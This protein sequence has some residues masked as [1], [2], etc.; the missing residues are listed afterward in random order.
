MSSGA[1]TF[2]IRK[3]RRQLSV[4]S[5]VT[6]EPP[7]TVGMGT[8]GQH[9][10][11]VENLRG[12]SFQLSASATCQEGT[13]LC[14]YPS[15]EPSWTAGP[16]D[17]HPRLRI[18]ESEFRNELDVDDVKHEGIIGPQPAMIATE[19][20]NLPYRSDA[21]EPQIIEDIDSFEDHVI[22]IRTC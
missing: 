18:S 6:P 13:G 8:R 22:V 12:G 7:A 9:V 14:Y 15:G 3:Y 11:N 1:A 2:V 19:I 17:F 10:I 20:F 5:T 21:L 4:T 16:K